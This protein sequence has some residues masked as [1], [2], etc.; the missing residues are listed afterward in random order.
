[1]QLITDRDLLDRCRNMIQRGCSCLSSAVGATS[2]RPAKPAMSPSV[3]VRGVPRRLG[4]LGPRP[5]AFAYY[6]NI[7]W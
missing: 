7:A 3:G 1:M 6:D 5:R 4:P 2:T